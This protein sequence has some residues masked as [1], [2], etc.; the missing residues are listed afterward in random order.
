[1][2]TDHNQ[3]QDKEEEH[4]VTT[5]GG[6]GGH[7]LSSGR[8]AVIV[9]ALGLMATA[10]K[11]VQQKSSSPTTT[12]VKGVNRRS[13]ADFGYQPWHQENQ[14]EVEFLKKKSKRS[15]Q[16]LSGESFDALN[17]PEEASAV[18]E[19]VTL[20]AS[21]ILDGKGLSVQ[22]DATICKDALIRGGVRSNG[23]GQEGIFV[24]LN[25]NIN[26]ARS[27]ANLVLQDAHVRGGDLSGTAGN[28]GEGLLSYGGTV[29]ISG[30]QTKI[31]GGLARDAVSEYFATAV[32]N[33]NG[34]MTIYDG[35]FGEKR[36][37]L[38]SLNSYG[39]D[40]TI[41]GGTFHGTLAIESAPYNQYKSY[42]TITGGTYHSEWAVD[43]ESTL[44]VIGRSLEVGDDGEDDNYNYYHLKGTLCSKDK[45]DVRVRVAKAW[46]GPG[47]SA[48]A[49]VFI[50]E[51][52]DDCNDYHISTP[53]TND[54]CGKK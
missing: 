2:M 29:S 15:A 5:G 54:K 22:G 6:S 10:A 52:V 11:I 41:H 46:D 28:G 20:D 9:A 17:I 31:I 49:G 43:I 26:L 42:A 21:N 35:I 45:V 13:L 47:P 12:F 1:M 4:R 37:T 14:L 44:A 25:K 39:G 3:P 18:L 19:Q 38:N 40:L 8:I 51:N 24:G 48:E 27:S 30:R 33:Y 7:N 50:V 36:F 34:V 23:Y 53:P 32:R 16:G